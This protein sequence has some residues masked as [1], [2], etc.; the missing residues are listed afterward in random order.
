LKV[1]I[2]KSYKI[3]FNRN[4]KDVFTAL[5]PRLSKK[6]WKDDFLRIPPY[7][8][9]PD[10]EIIVVKNGKNILANKKINLILV[11]IVHIKTIL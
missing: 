4:T 1:K 2:R 7:Y 6:A 8:H 11:E 10:T 9:E 3:A 5:W